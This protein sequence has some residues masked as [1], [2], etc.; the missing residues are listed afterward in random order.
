M[1]DERRIP[2]G[3]LGRLARLATVSA[4]AGAGALLGGEDAAAARAAEVLGTLRGLAAKMGQMASYVD[5]V[6]PE[7]QRDA[8]EGAMKSL[9]AATPR[10]SW[11]EVRALVEDELGGPLDRLFETFDEAPIAS[12]SIGQVHRA[13]MHDGRAV[14]VKVQHPGIARAI[15]S[16]LANAGMMQGFAGLVAGRRVDTRAMFDVLRERF[17]EELDYGLEAERLAH[18]AAVHEGDLDEIGRAHV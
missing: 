1:S 11:D 2:I 17:R 8:Y 14:A 16:D 15:E 18:F 7:G 13:T 6:V 3:R 5:G 4:R 9:R 10:S 12:A